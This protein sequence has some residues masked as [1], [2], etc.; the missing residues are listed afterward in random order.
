MKKDMCP[1]EQ[2]VPAISLC[3]GLP[4][5]WVRVESAGECLA[6]KGFGYTNS[7]YD[8]LSFT[9]SKVEGKLCKS[10]LLESTQHWTRSLEAMFLLWLCG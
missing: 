10:D 4:A 2:S 7:C 6:G 5:V 9:E 8:L 1:W 3:S